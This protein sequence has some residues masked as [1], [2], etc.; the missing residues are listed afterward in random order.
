MIWL[1]RCPLNDIY[2]KGTL[3]PI[4]FLLDHLFLVP[5]TVI[6]GREDKWT[7]MK[8]DRLAAVCCK[9]CSFHA[10]ANQTLLSICCCEWEE[11]SVWFSIMD[12]TKVLHMHSE[13]SF[14]LVL[15][16]S[17]KSSSQNI[18]ILKQQL[19]LTIHISCKCEY[20]CVGMTVLC[21]P[22]NSRQVG[23]QLPQ[24]FLFYSVMVTPGRKG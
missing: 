16:V 17:I 24:V 22:G 3:I 20:T 5:Q 18:I 8:C 14:F 6:R 11:R 1:K 10:D 23:Y 4:S 19:I 9:H 2:Y 15:S 21:V 7:R 13:P 12:S